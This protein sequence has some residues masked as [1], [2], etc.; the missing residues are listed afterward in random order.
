MIECKREL[1]MV[2]IK[3]I[4]AGNRSKSVNGLLDLCTLD[5]KE[6]RGSSGLMDTT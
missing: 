6:E 2:F 4:R 5:V 3:F 1:D